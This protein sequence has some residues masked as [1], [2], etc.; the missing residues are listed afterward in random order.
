MKKTLS[1]LG[2]IILTACGSSTS[3]HPQTQEVIKMLD[4]KDGCTQKVLDT[5]LD[6]TNT[7]Y[8]MN[9][10]QDAFG[11]FNLSDASVYDSDNESDY[12]ETKQGAFKSKWKI[13]WML[14][15]SFKRTGK[16]ANIEEVTFKK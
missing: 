14:D 10:D 15:K 16:I 7:F 5:Y 2:L 1:I 8:K 3:E 4:G 9:P 6:T 12:I 13:Q 11:D